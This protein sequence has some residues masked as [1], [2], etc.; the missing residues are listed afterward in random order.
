VTSVAI[1]PF[2]ELIL[3]LYGVSKTSM[4]EILLVFVY[5]A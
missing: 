3:T 1:G 5:E 4:L 2:K